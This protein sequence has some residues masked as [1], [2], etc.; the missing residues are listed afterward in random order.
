MLLVDV[1]EGEGYDVVSCSGGEEALEALRAEHYDLLLADIKM[2]GMT[3]IDLLDRLRGMSFD[4]V[5]VMMTA[6]ASVQTAVAALRGQ[7]FDYLEK[8][9]TL[10]RLRTCVQQA[11]RARPQPGQRRC[12]RSY[13]ELTIN[14][15]AHQLW[16]REQEVQLTRMEFDVLAHLFRRLGCAVSN[17]ELLEQV[18]GD[19]G[20]DSRGPAVVK[21]CVCRLRKKIGDDARQPRYIRNVRGFGYQ[22]GGAEL[23]Q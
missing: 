12:L 6:Y 22:L 11:L 3:G 19:D 7:A 4:T 10:E 17:E 15:D 20:S 21:S 13:G 14:M 8:P 23:D 9:F 16:A 5:V 2:A 18:W 1:L